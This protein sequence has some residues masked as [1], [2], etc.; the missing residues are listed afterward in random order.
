ML[1][2][3]SYGRTSPEV[4]VRRTLIVSTVSVVPRTRS[5]ESQTWTPIGTRGV[6]LLHR[7][8][9]THAGRV[10]VGARLRQVGVP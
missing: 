1:Y 3:L 9:Q 7:L 5:S 2:P 6:E 4:L 8:Y 10:Q